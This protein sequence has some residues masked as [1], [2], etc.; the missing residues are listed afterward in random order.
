MQ[1]HSRVSL[2]LSF[3][4]IE[5]AIVEYWFV[6]M[7]KLVTLCSDQAVKHHLVRLQLAP[8]LYR[9]LD[10]FWHVNKVIIIITNPPIVGSN[11]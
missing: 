7:E 11:V 3:T 5:G 9:E 8:C 10:Q 2:Y 4:C 1:F 6:S